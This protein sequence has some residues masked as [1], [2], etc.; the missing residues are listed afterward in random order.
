MNKPPL[1]LAMTSVTQGSLEAALDLPRS[2]HSPHFKIPSLTT[3]SGTQ[4]RK[5]ALSSELLVHD[6]THVLISFAFMSTP[7]PKLSLKLY[8]QDL[9]PSSTV[10]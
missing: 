5:G 4:S 9:S 6:L 1:P 3:S 8:G 10:L 2:Q 7:G